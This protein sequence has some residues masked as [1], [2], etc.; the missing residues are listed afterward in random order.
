MAVR[1]KAAP[2][3]K[4]IKTA[5]A[6]A[7]VADLVRE[8]VAIMA[9][10]LAPET[11]NVS[12]AAREVARARHSGLDLTKIQRECFDKGVSGTLKKRAFTMAQDVTPESLSKGDDASRA[13][14]RAAD[15]RRRQA[16]KAKREAENNAPLT[17][18]AFALA[19]QRQV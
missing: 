18:K 5:A 6:V 16:G 17:C 8:T 13:L 4:A 7:P 9:Y 3:S 12:A 10:H 2:R 19:L 15:N 11:Q 14:Q 1:P